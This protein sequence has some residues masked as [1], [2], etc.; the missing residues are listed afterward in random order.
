MS[1]KLMTVHQELEG[2]N[3]KVAGGGDLLSDYSPFIAFGCG[4]FPSSAFD[5]PVITNSYGSEIR[6]QILWKPTVFLQ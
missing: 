5:T 3:T 1:L 6:L 4:S 2:K